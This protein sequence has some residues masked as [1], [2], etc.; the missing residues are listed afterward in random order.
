MRKAYPDPARCEMRI[1]VADN[2]GTL[3]GKAP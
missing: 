1:V 2:E 3:P